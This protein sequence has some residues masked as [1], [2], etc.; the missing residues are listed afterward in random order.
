MK[1]D[2]PVSKFFLKKSVEETQSHTKTK[3]KEM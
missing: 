1:E 2:I 3:E